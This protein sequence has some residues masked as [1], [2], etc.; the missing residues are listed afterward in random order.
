MIQALTKEL[1]RNLFYGGCVLFLFMFLALTFDTLLAVSRH[2]PSDRPNGDTELERTIALGKS[3]W[4]END[5]VGCH[6]LL[7]DGAYLA[8]E[9]SNIYQRYDYSQEAVK[10]LIRY[11]SL[12]I[13]SG[14]RIMH[15]FDFS[16]QELNAIVEFLKY[17]SKVD[18]VHWP[19]HKEG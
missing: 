19:P 1:T 18:A 17:T 5:C 9:L 13:D 2:G 6:S 15:Q 11:R 14:Q 4:E 16:E 7:G 10:S 8:P 12:S 3:L